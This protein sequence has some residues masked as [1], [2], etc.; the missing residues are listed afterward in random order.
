[1]AVPPPHDPLDRVEEV[2]D[3]GDAFLEQVTDSARAA[4]QQLDG[5]ALFD[6]LG[7]HENRKTGNGLTG[8][9]RRA[10]ALVGEGGRH[11]D[12]DDREVR[13]VLL[14]GAQQVVAVVHG[15]DRL[16]VLVGEQS[17]HPR[18]QQNRVFGDDNPHAA[19]SVVSEWQNLFTHERVTIGT[20]GPRESPSDRR[21]G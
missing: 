5:V 19:P 4:G 2:P 16:D 10:Q 20:A 6:V 1:M 21:A 3:V 12:V 8:A 9:Q 14:D 15:G 7:K 17:D 18:A 13:P 11:A